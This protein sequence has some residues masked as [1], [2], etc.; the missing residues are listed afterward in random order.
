MGKMKDLYIDEMNRQLAED[1][2]WDAPEYNPASFIKA[3]TEPQPE[4]VQA[5]G[6]KLWI[7]P[8][9]KDGVDYKIWADSYQQALELLPM[10]E[11]F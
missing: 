3:D 6:K 10:I 5:D 11:S 8:S 1:A 7:I 9:N 4:I 2:N